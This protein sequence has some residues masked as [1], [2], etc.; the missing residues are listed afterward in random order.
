MIQAIVYTSESGFTKKYAELL[1]S[2]TGVPVFNLRQARSAVT[3]GSKIIYLG[4][5]MAGQVKGLAG[6]MKRYEVQAVCAVGMGLPCQAT[7]DETK[8]RHNTGDAAVWCLQGGFDLNK[9]HGIYKFMMQTMARSMVK[10]LSQKPDKTEEEKAML[11]LF[12]NGGDFVSAAS[13][14]PVTDWV[15]ARK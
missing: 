12:Q 11:D 15:N 14:A 5:L 6:A 3:D 8:R 2:Q 7:V 10:K 9:L 13:L 1:G 4:W